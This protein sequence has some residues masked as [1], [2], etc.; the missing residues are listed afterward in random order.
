MN[1]RPFLKRVKVLQEVSNKDR[2]VKLGRGFST[3]LR[4][5]PWNPIS[6]VVVVATLALTFIWLGVN[7]LANETDYKNPFKWN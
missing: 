5:N 6:Y 2:C 4:L 1:L 7:G 3:A